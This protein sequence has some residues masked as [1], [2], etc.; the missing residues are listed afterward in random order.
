MLFLLFNIR[1]LYCLIHLKINEFAKV[2]VKNRHAL[3]PRSAEWPNAIEQQPTGR[4]TRPYLLLPLR[5]RTP[6]VLAPARIASPGGKWP[7]G[8]PHG[9]GGAA[10]ARANRSRAPAPAW[11]R[12]TRRAGD[13]AREHAHAIVEVRGAATH[14]HG[15]RARRTPGN[16]TTLSSRAGAAKR[17]ERKPGLAPARWRQ[18][19]AS[20]PF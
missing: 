11:E 13:V 3:S 7:R 19:G 4:A 17:N 18:A 8:A 16:P 2:L 6:S 5:L 15:P 1:Q 9:A 10:D 12:R 14:G 20:D